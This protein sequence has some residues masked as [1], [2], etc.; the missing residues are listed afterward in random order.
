[1]WHKLISPLVGLLV[2][3][4]MSSCSGDE[5]SSKT[6]STTSGAASAAPVENDP[7]TP[8][9]DFISQLHEAIPETAD[10]KES[11]YIRLADAFC[12]FLDDG[13]TPQGVVMAWVRDGGDAQSASTLLQIAVPI[14]CP[15][16]TKVVERNLS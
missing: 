7:V 3:I 2:V 9:E 4:A 12:G 8:D 1:M 11:S 13:Y 15:Q 6:D 16:H 14:Y 10:G 5:P